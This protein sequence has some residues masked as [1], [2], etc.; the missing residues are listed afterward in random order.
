MDEPINIV[1]KTTTVLLPEI[2]ERFVKS[3]KLQYMLAEMSRKSPAAVAYWLRTDS[4]QI[5]LPHHQAIIRE[6]LNLPADEVIT[7]IIE[8]TEE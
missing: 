4:T 5:T 7:Q 2:K 6:L 8:V 3:V 1:P